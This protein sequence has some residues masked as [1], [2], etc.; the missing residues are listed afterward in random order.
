MGNII[1]YKILNFTLIQLPTTQFTIHSIIL[2]FYNSLDAT[3]LSPTT[4]NS[5]LFFPKENQRK[6]KE[7]T[8]HC[9]EQERTAAE[10]KTGFCQLKTNHWWECVHSD[11]SE[12]MNSLVATICLSISQIVH[13]SHFITYVSIQ[14]T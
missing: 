3:N 7:G 13:H 1:Y 10:N 11:W 14:S 9:Q 2:Y 4:F 8:R 12:E 5:P 6:Q